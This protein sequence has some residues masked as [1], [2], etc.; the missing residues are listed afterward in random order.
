MANASPVSVGKVNAGGSEDALFLK[1]FAGEVLTSFERASKTQGADMERSI[2][3][4]KS[5]TFPVMGRVGASYHTAGAEITGS[6]INHNEKVITINDLLISSV[7]L[8]NIEEAKNHWDVRSAYSQ[9]IGRALAFTKDKHILQ[10]IGQAAQGSANVADTSYASGT[11]LTNTGIASAT[12]STAANAMIDSLFD[13]AKQL[14]AN[15]VPSEGR[16]CFMRLE[17]Y[18]K[19]ANATNAVN[20]D[21][22]GKGSIADGKVLKIAGIELVPVAHFVS[23]NVNSGVDQGSA[24]A[25]GSNPQAVD[26][27]NYVALVSH[28]SAVG[29]VKLMDLGVEKE[30]DIRRQG[31]LMVAKYAMGHGVLRPEAAVGIKEA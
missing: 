21:F 8:S 25:G 11:V 29:T 18:Y 17:E 5:A 31:T 26:L 1:V 10:T 7:F 14:D 19:L 6:D 20:V 3:S 12:A 9:E 22:S 30:Y 28:P 27:S 16:K 4:G 2:S 15:Y 24:T 13:A 23:S